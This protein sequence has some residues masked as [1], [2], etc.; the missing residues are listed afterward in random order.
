MSDD[1]D[2]CC[3]PTGAGRYHQMT[4]STSGGLESGDGVL[5]CQPMGS[6]RPPLNAG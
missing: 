2:E 1:R 6:S 4:T 5:M 3:T